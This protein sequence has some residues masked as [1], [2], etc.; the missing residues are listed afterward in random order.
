MYFL[1]TER[2]EVIKKRKRMK[3]VKRVFIIATVALLSCAGTIGTNISDDQIKSLEIGKTTVQE[4]R[5]ALGKPNYETSSSTGTQ[6]IVYIWGR[7]H[8]KTATFIPIVGLFAGGATT[9]G[10]AIVL[11]FDS[12]GKLERIDRSS[13]NTDTSTSP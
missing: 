7:S 5:D 1:E 10:T 13:S 12:G 3:R 4:V 8:I 2:E 6:T 9:Q 11:S